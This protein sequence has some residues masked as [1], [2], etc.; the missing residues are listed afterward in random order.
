[1]VSMQ[2]HKKWS[3]RCAY[4]IDSKSFLA[5]CITVYCI[6]L[7]TALSG[8]CRIAFCNCRDS[9]VGIM[10]VVRINYGTVPGRILQRRFAFGKIWTQPGLNR[11]ERA[12]KYFSRACPFHRTPSR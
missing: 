9:D 3:L 5:V 6:E 10:A 2:T 1:M 12:M 4:V 7:Q 11:Q 8:L